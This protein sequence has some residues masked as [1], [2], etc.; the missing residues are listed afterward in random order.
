M[1][2]IIGAGNVP[3]LYKIEKA[4]KAL[5]IHRNIVF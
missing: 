1:P 2:A 3:W 5:F 4:A